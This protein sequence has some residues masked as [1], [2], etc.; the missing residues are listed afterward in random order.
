MDESHRQPFVLKSRKPI[1]GHVPD[2]SRVFDPKRQLWILRDSGLPV[3]SEH[4][5]PNSRQRSDWGETV[6]TKTSE[7]I[8]QSEGTRAS[9][10]GET[11]MTE[12]SEGVDQSESVRASDFGETVVTA[13]SEGHDQSERISDEGRY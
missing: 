2:P 10:W 6:M 13:T 11:V 9:D 12:T 5:R 4:A 7:G 3:V 8:D 1:P